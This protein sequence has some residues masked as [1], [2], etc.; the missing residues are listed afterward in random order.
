MTDDI[1]SGAQAKAEA[2]TTYLHDDR[3]ATISRWMQGNPKL[4]E[5]VFTYSRLPGKVGGT[6]PGSSD[7]CE[8]ICYAKRVVMNV[9]VWDVWR[10]NSQPGEMVQATIG[11]D[12]YYER[13]ELPTLPT[14]AKLVRIHVS[15][16][17]DTVAYVRAWLRLVQAHPDVKFWGYTRS[18][19]V[20]ELSFHLRALRDQPNVQLFAS[21]DESIN[22]MPHPDWRRAWIDGDGRLVGEGANRHVMSSRTGQIERNVAFVCPEE[23]GIKASCAACGYCID[24]Q[25]NDVIFL[26]H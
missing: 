1:R 6:C 23:R 22:E 24:G 2:T 20:E 5:G 12:D 13:Y 3:R 26:K 17:F 9:P 4:G 19:R 15:G 11:G 10:L 14:G 21:I 8:A 18:W 7:E 25:R 16:D